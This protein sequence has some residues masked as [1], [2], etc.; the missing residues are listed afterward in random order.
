[1]APVRAPDRTC[2][3]VPLFGITPNLL[4]SGTSASGNG[5]EILPADTSDSKY[6]STGMGFH[7]ADNMFT[8]TDHPLLLSP[9]I[10]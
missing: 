4:T 6:C 1:M 2:Y 3:R 7:T 8:G 9:V 5:T 10:Q